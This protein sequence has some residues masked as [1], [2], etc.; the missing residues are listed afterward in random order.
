MSAIP[1]S[2]LRDRPW[3]S[4]YASG[5]PHEIDPVTE[6]LVDLLDGAVSR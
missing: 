4:S 5:V 1:S 6:T 2:P 3:L